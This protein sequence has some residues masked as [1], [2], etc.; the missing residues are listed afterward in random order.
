MFLE[1]PTIWTVE[2]RGGLESWKTL[3]YIPTDDF[4]PHG[5]GLFTR[6]I[7]RTIEYSYNDFC[8]AEMAQAMNKTA[9]AEKYMGRSGN[10]INMFDP[11]SR[12]MLNVTDPTT[13]V[14]SGFQ[15]FMQPR[16]A[17]GTFG[18]QDPA[19]CTHVFN[20]DACY[21]NPNGHETYEAGSWLYT[22]YVPHDQ[23]TLS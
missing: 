14:D 18:Y 3:G 15:G 19:I 11:D 20:F 10:W 7:S 16:Y 23:A 17:N 21:L 5:V 13:F 4:D 8:I 22:F 1:Q 6:S 9:D 2:G 12:S